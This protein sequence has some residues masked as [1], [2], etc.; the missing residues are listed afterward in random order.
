MQGS[1][2]K[3]GHSVT[4][5]FAF[6]FLVLFSNAASAANINLSEVFK[7]ASPSIVV[8]N[9]YGGEG[10]GGQQGSGVVIEQDLI[11]TNC[12]VLQG[13]R[14]IVVAH[15]DKYYEANLANAD[16]A[17]DLCILRTSPHLGPDAVPASIGTTRGLEVGDRVV[18]IGAP[19]GLE[20]SLSEGVISGL[21]FAEEHPLLQITTPISPGSSGGGLFDREGR[22][23]GLTT[24]RLR[25][26]QQLNFALP[27]EWISEVATTPL[28]A[29]A[30]AQIQRR[31]RRPSSVADSY[32]LNINHKET[33]QFQPEESIF[34]VVQ[35]AADPS[36][37]PAF[38]TA[39][40]WKREAGDDIL[41]DSRTAYLHTGGELKALEFS[42][43]QDWQSGVYYVFVTDEY[44]GNLTYWKRHEFCVTRRGQ[45][46]NRRVTG[47]R[48]RDNDGV[49]HTVVSPPHQDVTAT[50]IYSFTVE[51]GERWLIIFNDGHEQISIDQRSI[52]TNGAIVTAW[53]RHL[54][55]PA[56]QGLNDQG[57][58]YLEQVRFDCANRLLQVES[59]GEYSAD[60]AY[61]RRRVAG[62]GQAS[63]VTPESFG[64]IMMMVACNP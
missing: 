20:L 4:T 43:T 56:V 49:S 30:A 36:V 32:V 40:L 10:S 15:A 52:E 33:I 37:L 55:S 27:V 51:E 42:R 50:P 39:N 62:Q 59:A 29:D 48:Y 17:R 11:A 2:V 53:F 54:P 64:E 31:G 1:I 47:W 60:G 26:S 58:E 5:I 23:I 38:I 44:A 8:I 21:R 28:S 35:A 57:A 16:A 22:L 45:N 13:N 18:S 24:L 3:A 19:Q 7:K 25:D 46:C 34:A 14:R 63:P 12:H 9:A 6:F 41:V 61:E